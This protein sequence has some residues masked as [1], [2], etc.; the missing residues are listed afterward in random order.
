M[1]KLDVDALDEHGRTALM[2]TA[3]LGHL[4]AAQAL[5]RLGA[6]RTLRDAHVGW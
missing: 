2:W 1:L 5:L 6:D 3:E 4:S